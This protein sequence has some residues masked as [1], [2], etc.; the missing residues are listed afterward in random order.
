M[1]L[2]RCFYKEVGCIL[3]GIAFIVQP[4]CCGMRIVALH[5]KV[6]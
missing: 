6:V 3:L 2:K 1:A 5:C 4:C